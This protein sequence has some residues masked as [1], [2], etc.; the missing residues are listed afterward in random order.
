MGIVVEGA[1]LDRGDFSYVGARKF[2]PHSGLQGFIRT[3]RFLYS[4]FAEGRSQIFVK[5]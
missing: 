2:D 1:S 5:P 4:S 3:A